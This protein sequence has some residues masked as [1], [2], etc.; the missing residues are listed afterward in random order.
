MPT[1]TETVP[2]APSALSNLITSSFAAA[3]AAAAESPSHAIALQVLHNLQHQ[4]L[5]TD[6]ALHAEQ[7]LSEHQHAPLV[8]GV[9]PQKV[10]VHPD[11]QV[12]L[13][14][15][16]VRSEDTP[17][18]REYVLPTRQ[19]ERWTL[20]R[21]S[22][23]MDSLPDKNKRLGGEPVEPSQSPPASL[24]KTEGQD[25][26]FLPSGASSDH[27]PPRDDVEQ[28]EHLIHPPKWN[29]KHLLLAMVNTGMGGDGTISY[30]VILD[31]NVK[32]RQN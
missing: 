25:S 5:W 29:D 30:Y 15:H 4:H 13:L 32:P 9:P 12:Y 19:G 16:G 2:P 20:R 1:A 7:S 11:E 24:K 6:L 8:S 10:Y 21:L 28:E 14:E 18:Y 3:A 17:P 23:V 27:L 22:E 31:G 26:S